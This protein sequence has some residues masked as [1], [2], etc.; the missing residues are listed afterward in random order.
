[1][2]HAA[3]VQRRI[4]SGFVGN[5]MLENATKHEAAAS[6]SPAFAPNAG[7]VCISLSTQQQKKDQYMTTKSFSGLS[8]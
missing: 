4:I 3:P 7:F 5:T 2:G 6:L 1:M 8:V